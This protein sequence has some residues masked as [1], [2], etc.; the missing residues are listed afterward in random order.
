MYD[1]IELYIYIRDNP[2]GNHVA[3]LFL[4]QPQ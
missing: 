4:L 1:Y 2:N 3:R